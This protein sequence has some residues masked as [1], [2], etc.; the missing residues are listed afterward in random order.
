[1]YIYTKSTS[2]FL[3]PLVIHWIVDVND[4]S[5]TM[6]QWGSR[7]GLYAVEGEQKLQQHSS[8]HK[9]GTFIQVSPIKSTRLHLT[10]HK[11][12]AFAVEMCRG[13]FLGAVGGSW[14]CGREAVPLY[15]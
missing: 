6:Q 2:I 10:R 12:W 13:W 1:M 15:P 7:L 9:R 11:T 3:M 14:C 5:A 4:M 8:L